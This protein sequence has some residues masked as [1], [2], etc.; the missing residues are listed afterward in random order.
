MKGVL[1]SKSPLNQF[2]LLICICLASLFLLGAVLTLVLAGITGV[3]IGLLADS[4]KWNPND[5]RIITMIRGMQ[6]IQFLALFVLPSLLCARLFSFDSKKYLGL[7]KASD[8]IYFLLGVA[9]LLFAIPLANLLGVVNQD[10]NLPR[11]IAKWMTEQ[12]ENAQRT[13]RALLSRHT[14]KD[15]IINIICI[16]G[17]AAVG[18]ELLF[19]GVAQKLLIRMFKSP[20]LGI[21]VAAFLF[22]AMHMQFYGFLPRFLLGILLGYIYWYSGSLWPAIVAHFVYDA[23]LVTMVYFDPTMMNDSEQTFK[24]SNLASTGAISAVIVTALVILMRKKSTTTFEA[25]YAEDMEPAKDH[26]F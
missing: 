11:G 13:V 26:P 7:K 16:A 12:E 22:S 4:T 1:K 23:F 17:F 6:F 18:E 25:V 24:F 21:L 2:L 20:L 14:I 9:I 5:G 19:R 10:I 3:D 15:L 8:S